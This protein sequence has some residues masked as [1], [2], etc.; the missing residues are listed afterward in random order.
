MNKSTASLLFS[1]L[2]AFGIFFV[3]K[4][5]EQEKA[6]AAETQ[7]IIESQG[8]QEELFEKANK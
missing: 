8:T 1:L 4:K 3:L 5:I 2:G 7:R 6:R